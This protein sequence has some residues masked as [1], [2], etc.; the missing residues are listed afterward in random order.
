[1]TRR[2]GEELR[3]I[4]EQSPPVNLPGE[5]YERARRRHRARALVGAAG[6]GVVLV[7]AA[8]L[9]AGGFAPDRFIPV[10]DGPGGVRAF[11]D[12]VGA[13]NW[14]AALALLLVALGY[15]W[16]RQPRS[17]RRRRMVLTAAVGVVFVLAAPP[18]T[19]VCCEPRGAPGLPDRLATPMS[20]TFVAEARQSPPGPVALIFSGPATFGNLEEGRLAMVAADGE[21]Y[22]VL[23]V[24]TD[25]LGYSSRP[26]HAAIAVDRLTALLSP[27]GR[28][29]FADGMLDLVTGGRG[30]EPPGLPVGWSADG[31]R[32]VCELFRDDQSFEAWAVWDLRAGEIVGR[33]PV[34]D[35]SRAGTAALSSDGEHL[36]VEIGG[37]LRIYDVGD[38]ASYRDVPLAGWRLGGPTAWSPDN[39]MLALVRPDPPAVRLVSTPVDSTST[40]TPVAEFSA[41]AGSAGAELRL[42]GWRSNSAIVVQA[43]QAVE[44]F[45][46][47][48]PE[49]ERLIELP[50]GVARVEIATVA[51]TKAR[52]RAGPPTY[53]PPNPFFWIVV[54]PL[55]GFGLVVVGAFA[56]SALV[57]RLRRPDTAAGR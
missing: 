32:V 3:A 36:A 41:L 24:F 43:G 15:V 39:R 25:P 17:I 52:Y 29:L 9:L 7:A 8:T 14:W 13:A 12:G 42:Q 20:W 48:R 11:A 30:P 2:L 21:R 34:D 6:A 55:A 56:V 19:A 16:R 53:G 31:R 38:P 49:P 45:E 4:A 5:L 27:N 51:L 47:D 44:S 40:L 28:Y 35:P 23:D 57:R 10:G 54:A 37:A 22:R 33:I 26:G 46:V 18:G 1:M 50:E